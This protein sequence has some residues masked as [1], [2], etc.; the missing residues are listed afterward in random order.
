MAE[1]RIDFDEPYPSVK[2]GSSGY[3]LQIH[4]AVP[5]GAGHILAVST[6]NGS[7]KFLV[8]NARFSS[9]DGRERF[10]TYAAG[11]LNGALQTEEQRREWLA[12]CEQAGTLMPRAIREQRK[13]ETEARR[14]QRQSSASTLTQDGLPTITCNQRQLRDITAEAFQTLTASN[15]P[16]R[17]FKRAAQLV[18]VALVEQLV[19][20]LST[21]KATEQ[22]PVIQPLG[23][24]ALRGELARVANWVR[25]SDTNAYPCPP[26]M[27]VV[28]DLASMESWPEI[29]GLLDVI[30]APALRPDGSLIL[31]PG[32]DA[33]TAVYYRPNPSLSLPPIPKEP[34]RQEIERAL[35][36]IDD[37]IGEFPFD[38]AASMSN[39]I[40]LLL[41]PVLRPCLGSQPCPMAL[42]DA[43]QQGSGKSLLARVVSIVATGQ[44]AA[45]FTAP[46]EEAEWRKAITAIVRAGSPFVLIDNV[47]QHDLRGNPIPLRS[48]ALSAL[49]TTS[50]H[51]D[52]ILGMTEMIEL[53]TRA[54]WA[55][56]GN[57]VQVGGDMIRRCYRVRIDPKMSRPWLRTEFT[58]PDLIEYVRGQRGTILAALLTLARAW[59]A[60][61]R[62]D[63][64]SPQLGSFTS[65]SRTVGGIL[66]QA[67]VG[68]FLSDQETL[69]A[70]SDAETPEW[71]AFLMC[72][73]SL[74]GDQWITT[75][76][77]DGVVQDMNRPLRDALPGQ[78]AS[79]FNT[80]GFRQKLGVQLR[81]KLG[82][83]HGDAGLYLE[84]ADD[85]HSKI[86]KWRV[87]AT[88]D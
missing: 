3:Q 86:A 29:P 19:S 53:P 72:W 28:K 20:G 74:W 17:I 5:D 36:V 81:T 82:T 76:D 7:H 80:S 70:E 1:R 51:R 6:W 14:K 37:I 24:S 55:L 88:R 26:P 62:P 15:V 54:T 18:R 87:A 22:R 16:P 84:H 78:L 52:R 65:W 69:Y 39:A 23:E 68:G 41:T 25:V 46:T 64:S 73:R 58:H 79:Q 45:A 48:A 4:A 31:E 30:E 21:E 9:P 8:D 27:D 83:R 50:V 43:P 47:D 71:E 56:S 40:G 32:Y 61:G 77:V 38:S 35:C 57:N 75:A 12:A 11:Q 85:K 59:F 13:R 42:L 44:E 63:S 33:A 2:V 66:Q 49:L 60:A 10:V 67:G 34:S